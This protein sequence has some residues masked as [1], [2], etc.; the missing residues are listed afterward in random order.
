MENKNLLKI[1]TS[2]EAVEE[3]KLAIAE[4]R[5]GEQLALLSRHSKIKKALLGGWR[6]GNNYAICGAS[7]SGKSYYLNMLYQDF[8]NPELNRDFNKPFKILH[9]CFEMAAYDEIIRAASGNLKTSYREILS[10]DQ[11]LPDAQYQ[12]TLVYLDRF[13]EN[14]IYYVEST[15]NYQQIENTILQFQGRFPQHSLVIGYDHTLLTDYLNERNEVEL[16]TNLSKMAVRV[17]K[18]INCMNLEICQLNA[19][20]ENDERIINPVHHYPKK[21]DIHGAK[22]VYRDADYVIVLHA[23]EMLGIER[24]GKTIYDKNVFPDGDDKIGYPAKDLIMWHLLK[25]R[26]GKP[27]LIRLKNKLNIGDIIQWEV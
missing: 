7:G 2:S 17:R 24:Y 10:I 27:G 9:F 22:A 15:G 16:V 4:G 20:I 26:K 21:R 11:I 23:P 5:T 8:F 14:E 1:K 12:N 13:K 6:F 25:A 18:K 19:D 3:A